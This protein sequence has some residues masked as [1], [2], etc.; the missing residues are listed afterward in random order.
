M[1]ITGKRKNGRPKVTWGRVIQAEI[2]KKRGHH[3]NR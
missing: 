3:G 2:E 1:I